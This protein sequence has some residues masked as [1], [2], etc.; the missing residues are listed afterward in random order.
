[1]ADDARSVAFDPRAP[2]SERF[3]AQA[4]LASKVKPS[5]SGLIPRQDLM[6]IIDMIRADLDETQM[7]KAASGQIIPFPGEHTN[8]GLG[9][10][11]MKSVYLDQL[12][13]FVSG[14]YYEKPSPLGFEQ[15]RQMVEQTPILNA[16]IMTRIRQISRFCQMSED[17]GPGFEI[18]HV[19]RS[20][21]LT[22]EEEES[23]KL[24]A[25]FI[26][27]CG[28]EFSPRKRKMMKRDS[29]TQFMAKSVRDSLTF[30]AAPIE[31][32]FKRDRSLGL[33]G[34]YAVD[35][36]TIRL[37]TDEGYEGDDRI[38]A[39][40]VIQGRIATA[41]SHDQLVY[42]VRNPR[43][44]VRLAGYGMG[45]CELLVRVVT[46]FLNAMA[47]NS[48]GFDNNAIPKGILQLTGDYDS[49]DLVAFKR[50]WN[51]TVKGV[52]NAWALP[53]MVAKDSDA[54]VSFEK[55]G[56]D[57]NEM[58][59]A[60]WMT[61]LT[62]IICAIYGMAPDE[63][64]FESFAASKSSL[65]GS[66]TEE[67][68]TNSRDLGLHPNMAYY[69]AMISDFI[70]AE[71]DP[72]Y[73]FRWAGVKQ[74]D[75]QK[76]WEA[77]K[78]VLTVDELRAEQ[79]YKPHPDPKIGALPLNP[80]MI[81]PAMQ[82]NQAP[83]PGGDFGGQPGE[84][85]SDFGNPDD[86]AGPPDDGQ[87]GGQD[88]GDADGAPDGD[89]RPGPAA[90]PAPGGEFGGAGPNA[91]RPSGQG[92]FGKALPAPAGTPAPGAGLTIYSVDG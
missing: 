10:R 68:L 54:K 48:A 7:V 82:L 58:M 38:Y 15:L 18:R 41:Y 40:Q 42:E 64:N 13:I 90:A 16:V 19:D 78:L 17:G 59:F 73:C 37:C 31:T 14:D 50:Y 62:S 66:D 80:S 4:E 22:P 87:D 3:D 25:R 65:S 83:A 57:Y 81:G 44:D 26:A 12:Q 53:V 8:R 30:D 39:L 1:M 86:G 43:T 46:G 33:D 77:K 5:A 60:K 69:E 76:L 75:E 92:D 9:T 29:F 91:G 52:N 61:F 55:F 56:V 28:W 74:E 2:A 23:T 45:E 67:K 51:Q 85:A 6:P 21:K 11:G 88:G 49:G 27:N 32:E 84:A 70:V 20:H 72:K 63:I 34:F 24:M 47:Y 35:G 71:F 79:G 36:S 89:T